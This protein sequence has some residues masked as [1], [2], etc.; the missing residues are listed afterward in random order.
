[1]NKL[2]KP[3]DLL[4]IALLLLGGTGFWFYA[5]HSTAHAAAVIYIDGEVYQSISLE[6]VEEPY[7][8]PLPCSPRATLLVEK[9][10]VSFKE[11]E[12]SDKVCV[13]TGKLTKRGDTAACLPAK[14]VVTI[15]NGEK[16]LDA[17]V[18]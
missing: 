18:Y 16:Q 3:L 12:C 9:G 11:A 4:L 8:L 15:E 1:M 17:M 10:A 14:V 6:K 5:K 2:I 13:N 7:E